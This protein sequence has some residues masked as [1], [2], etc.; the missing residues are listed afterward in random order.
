MEGQ[1]GSKKQN[2]VASKHLTFELAEKS[3][4]GKVERR[5][6]SLFV[7]VIAFHRTRSSTC[8]RFGSTLTISGE[9][10]APRWL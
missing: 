6:L 3:A 7:A 1:I 8:T 2:G 9:R 4:T 10:D 5:W